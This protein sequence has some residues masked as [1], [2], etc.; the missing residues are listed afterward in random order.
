M[1]FPAGSPGPVLV[2]KQLLAER[3]LGTVY[4]GGLS[5]FSLTVMVVSFLQVPLHLPAPHLLVPLHRTHGQI[6][7]LYAAANAFARPRGWSIGFAF[8]TLTSYPRHPQP[9]Q[10]QTNESAPR[11]RFPP[12]SP[13]AAVDTFRMVGERREHL[14]TRLWS[15]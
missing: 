11:S 9:S 7:I 3:G 14:P 6:F 4:T 13:G 5:S 2:L 8:D 12:F 15:T 10:L 1:G